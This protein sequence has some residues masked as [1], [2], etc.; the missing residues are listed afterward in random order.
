MSL[1]A[2]LNEFLRSR[3][4][5]ALRD[6]SIR[7]LFEF[8]RG[9]LKETRLWKYIVMAKA[10]WKKY[11]IIVP[12]C[13]DTVDGSYKEKTDY[14]RD[15]EGE[16]TEKLCEALEF[17]QRLIADSGDAVDGEWMD[18]EARLESGILDT[19]VVTLNKW[20]LY[21]DFMPEEAVLESHGDGLLYEYK[22]HSVSIRGKYVTEYSFK[23]E[24]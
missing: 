16:L 1:R 10:L 23:R 11:N 8:I 14:I 19:D 20:I 18:T 22:G 2:C 17:R 24:R 5:T 4:L 12:K 21:G 6:A 9:E 3:E 7:V 15:S 13:V